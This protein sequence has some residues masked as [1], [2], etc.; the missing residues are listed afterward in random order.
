MTS[1]LLR[2]LQHDPSC[3]TAFAILAG[4][5]ACGGS[6]DST[7]PPTP[8]SG[9]AYVTS[10]DAQGRPVP[11]ALYQYAIGPDGSLT[12]SGAGSIPTGVNPVSVIADPTGRYVYIANLGDAT[13]AQY[14]VGAGGRLIALSP[15]VVGVSVPVSSPEG[16]WLSVDASGRF[17]YIVVSSVGT[18]GTLAAIAQYAIGSG[19]ALAPLSPAYVTAPTTA[20]GALAIDPAGR[21]AYLAGAEAGQVMQFAVAGDGTLSPLQPVGGVPAAAWVAGV[22]VAPSGKTLYVLSGCVDNLCNGQVAQYTIGANG[23]VTP[24]GIT[25]T[26]GSHVN[27]VVMMADSSVSSAYLLTNL[28]GVDTNAGA[29]YQYALDGTDALTPQTPVSVPVTSGAVAESMWSS[30]LYALSADAIGQA[31]GSLTGGHLDHYTIGTDGLLHQMGTTTVAGSLP[32]AMTIAV[33]H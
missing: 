9:Y 32:T 33:I 17:L 18:P 26:T 5:A 12:P 23:A 21:Y 24:T 20:F 13:I 14:A 7:M 22:V 28:M 27:P 8:S 15:A 10:A 3:V 2:R 19:G 11:G 16:Y 4:L 31:S 6:G 30:H 25:T 29:V 1:R